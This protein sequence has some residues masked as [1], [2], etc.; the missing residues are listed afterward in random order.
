MGN[1]IAVSNQ[2]WLLKV[3]L[4]RE[5]TMYARELDSSTKV[6]HSVERRGDANLKVNIDDDPY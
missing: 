5:N 4:E 1:L 2:G 6:D 3:L